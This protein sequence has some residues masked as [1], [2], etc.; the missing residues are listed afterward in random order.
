[1]HADGR[2]LHGMASLELPRSTVT[3]EQHVIAKF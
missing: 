2:S 1:M 3:Q